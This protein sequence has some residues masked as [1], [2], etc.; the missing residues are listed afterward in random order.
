MQNIPI[1]K[2]AATIG[3]TGLTGA[4]VWLNAEHLAAVEGW[5]SP[6]VVAG[7]IVTICAASTP[8]LAERASKSGQWFKAV[9]LWTFF[10]LAVAFSL[11]AS[12]TRSS[13][14]VEG[15]VANAAGSNKAAQLA[16]EAYEAAKKTVE[17]ECVKRGQ[18]CREAEE[19]RDK[20][21][22]KLA[23]A[24]PV[25]SSDPGAERLAAVLGI[26]PAQV[27]L[28]APLLLPLGLELGGFIFLAF[29][30]APRAREIAVAT[31]ASPVQAVAEPMPEFV[32]PVQGDA[33][34]AEPV[35][36]AIASEDAPAKAGT[37]SYYLQRLEREFPAIAARVQAGEVSV[38]AACVEVG[39]RKA[40]KARKWDANEYANVSA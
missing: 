15:K 9:V 6:L 34:P 36:M 23:T 24:A 27:Q 14:Y 33:I 32:S 22:D 18:K 21:R 7:I 38:F 29:G 17:A 12:I 4:A 40:P 13:G 2:V 20:A 39:I 1:W 25:Q 5:H 28:Y 16:E 3:G 35:A 31:V 37:R 11:S 19:K 10:G 26:E 8:P 30:L